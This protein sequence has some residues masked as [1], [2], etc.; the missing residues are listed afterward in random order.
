MDRRIGILFI[1]FVALLGIALARAMYLGSVRA[2]SLERAA[3]T[4]QVSNVVVPAARG[5]IT[6]RD[7]AELA[8]SESADDVVADPYLIKNAVSAAAELS[9]ALAHPRA[10][11]AE[12]LTKP[13]TGYVLLA[14]LVPSAQAAAIAKLHIA[15]INLTPQTRR[16]Y[17]RGTE[18]AQLIGSVHLDGDG[19]ERHRVPVQPRAAGHER[20]APDR[21]RRDRAA[22]LDRRPARGA[23]PARRSS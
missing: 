18:A 4:Q 3:A 17:P 16:V 22:D 21:Q 6:D 20:R 15:G 1:A 12:S 14:H 7:G 8:I 23:I 13:H 5:A 2:G 11:A 19:A 10:D 9:P